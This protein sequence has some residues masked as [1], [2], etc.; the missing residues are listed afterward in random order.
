MSNAIPHFCDELNSLINRF[1]LEYDISY[2]ELVG[3]LEA[4]K[5]QMI[6]E[7]LQEPEKEPSE[8]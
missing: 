3:C 1:R 6:M 8:T 7:G 4:H 2:A 5:V